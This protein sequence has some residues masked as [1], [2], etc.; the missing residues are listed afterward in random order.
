MRPRTRRL[1]P[2][3]TA[4]FACMTVAS[5][6]WLPPAGLSRPAMAGA[7]AEA[8]HVYCECHQHRL[9]GLAPG[10]G[11]GRGTFNPATGEDNRN[12]PPD[13][14]VA[15]QGMVLEVT[16]P[17]LAGKMFTATQRLT[18][19]PI[20]VPVPALELD[21]EGLKILA[22]KVDGKDAE[23]THD[24][25]VLS[26]R[27]AKPLVAPA[28]GGAAQPV[29]ITTTYEC[30]D[31]FRGMTFS[32]ATPEIPGVARA[33][34]AELHT[35]GQ[36][37]T[38]H[39]WFPIHDSP[40]VRLPT[41]LIINVPKGMV[42]SSNGALVEQKDSGDRSIWHWKQAKPHVPYLVT[43]V[44]GDFERIQLPNPKSKVPMTVWAAPGRADDVRATFA[45]TDA[46]VAL[47][48]KRLGVKY[49]WDRYDQLVVRN[50]GAGGM[51]NTSATTLQPSS[52]LDPVARKEQDLDG[53]I[54]HELCHQW[55]GDLL[56]C[57]SWAHIWLN[58]GWA[59]YGTALWM[60]ER[61]GPDG[62]YDQ[63]LGNAGVADRDVVEAE[64]AMCSPVWSNA[65]ETFG[66]PAN[67]YPKG[68]SILHM[69]RR[70]LGDEV[71][72]RGVQ[73]YMQ[74]HA[75]GL[76]ETS[77]FRYA[78]EEASG[79]G[80]EWFFDQ[81]CDR[82]GSPRVTATTSYDPATRTLTLKA[83]QTQKM[84]ARTPAL[85][86]TVPVW[87]KT[88]ASEKLVPCW[89]D[90]KTAQ[91]QV[92]L[93]GPPVA[94]WVDPY[95]D[96][97]KVLTV[98]QPE[99]W[100]LGALQ[101]APTIAA[102]RQAM[103]LLAKIETAAARAALRA[104][105]ADA[106]ARH[107]LRN[108]AIAALAAYGSTDAKRAVL[109][110]SDAGSPDPR[111]MAAL[112]SALAKVDK[113]D[114]TPRLMKVLDPATATESYGVRVAAIDAL[115][116][117]D[118]RDA[119]PLIRGQVGLP[120]QGENVS[121]AALR[122]LAKWGEAQDVAAVMAR[123]QLGIADRARPEAL[124]TLAAMAP[125]LSAEDRKRIEAFLIK[126]LDDPE[127]RTA[128]AA[129]AALAALKCKDALPQLQAIADHHRDPGR[130]TR[131]AGW[132]KAVKGA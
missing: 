76:V 33:R 71:F 69:L 118:V 95:L 128:G 57:R 19:A 96:S 10:E 16:V 15:Y 21:A 28:Q 77:D 51:E 65:G 120:S 45:N 38:N 100:T 1:N 99:A 73:K 47:L 72:F 101:S 22:V 26:I 70:M 14:L 20:G 63:V 105:A 81:W 111:V 6:L 27:F 86:I 87:V 59:T 17:D 68:A 89:M 115:V 5:L 114:A 56:T 31:P 35:Q 43:L 92:E 13:P 131:A 121:Q 52:V 130:R 53:L 55:T 42:A 54:S 126:M 8:E 67:P 119:L 124:E 104:V 132:V 18:V 40:N 103:A 30:A 106:K 50:F 97:L 37:E 25:K 64:Q 2:I 113:A 46:M 12:F 79:L 75:G 88:A 116:A 110:L 117:L 32:P 4:P 82:P 24:G 44:A 91:L 84:D 62:Y 74:A 123:A 109:E 102:R 48:E 127:G 9:E 125:R 112:T 3:V 78:M 98:E 66:R 129:G 83:E 49:P 90:Q 108:A 36:T 85:R 93:D 34:S 39:Y 60:E 7:E 107:T 61:D 41:E 94:V 58:E 29:V 122:A 23:W 80:L 11:E